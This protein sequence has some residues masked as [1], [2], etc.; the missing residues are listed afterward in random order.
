[1]NTGNSAMFDYAAKSLTVGNPNDH[2]NL[3][4]GHNTQ[5]NRWMHLWFAIPYLVWC[6]EIPQSQ[7]KSKLSK[8]IG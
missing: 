4:D 2:Q 7:N 3:S 1:M 8:V 5:C 6:D